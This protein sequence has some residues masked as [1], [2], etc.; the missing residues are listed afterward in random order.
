LGKKGEAENKDALQD[1][2]KSRGSEVDTS[3]TKGLGLL[4]VKKKKSQGGE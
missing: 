4:G 1:S 3:R 2:V